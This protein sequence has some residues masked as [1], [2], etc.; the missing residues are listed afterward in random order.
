MKK[1]KKSL[2]L[3]G[4]T[5]RELW[6]RLSVA[7]AGEEARAIHKELKKYGDSVP[8]SVRYPNFYIVMSVIS[9]IGAIAVLIKQVIG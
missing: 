3:Q 8:F 7:K 6:E 2:E 1:N 4:L 5:Q 9:L